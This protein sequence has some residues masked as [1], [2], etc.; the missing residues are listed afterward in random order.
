MSDKM[1]AVFDSSFV[2]H[3]LSTLLYHYGFK[4]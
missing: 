4:A 2:T 3:H 1:K